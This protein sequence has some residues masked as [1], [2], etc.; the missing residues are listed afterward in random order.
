MFRFA[1]EFHLT[2]EC[3]C[4]TLSLMCGPT[5][6]HATIQ[7]PLINTANGSCMFGMVFESVLIKVKNKGD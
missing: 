4:V 7:V 2:C 5:K 6:A 1:D 3:E